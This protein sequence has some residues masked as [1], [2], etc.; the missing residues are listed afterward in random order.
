MKTN[1]LCK[2]ANL[3]CTNGAIIPVGKKHNTI[4][5]ILTGCTSKRDFPKQMKKL[6]TIMQVDSFYLP[7]IIF[8]LS[9]RSS[10]SQLYK[11]ILDV[12]TN[13]VVATL[14]IYQTQAANN[15]ISKEELLDIFIEQ[16][17]SGVGIITIHPTPTRR[18]I[19]LAQKRL[20][21]ITSRGGAIVVDDLIVSGRSENI[22]IEI[23]DEIIHEC[24]KH[25][26]TI[27]IGASFRS[28][29]IF[30]SLDACQIEEFKIQKQIG[31][32]ISSKGVD[33][34]IEGP[35]H[36]SLK[37]LKKISA[38]YNNMNFPIMPLGPIPTDVS[39]GQDH[40]ASSIGAAVLGML[41]CVDIITSVTREE[42]TGKIPSIGA[43]IEALKAAKITAHT[44]NI[45]KVDYLELD[46]LVCESR[47]K[48]KTCIYG[49]ETAGCD[50]CANKCPLK[51]TPNILFE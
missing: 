34:V 1:L 19:E 14:P 18:L 28:A 17:E 21:P 11:Q 38:Y 26:V 5:S 32:Y 35:G 9:L 13:T 4:V 30:D 3:K 42:H 31:K 51:N 50:R 46:K 36:S 7:E 23:L 44:L 43:T 27:S 12:T 39:I 24:L 48:Y 8:D 40:I 10:D 49:K 37:T 20:V 33:V 2:E 29:N 47:I 22:Y 41:G 15:K 16:V 25:N 6:E 45:D